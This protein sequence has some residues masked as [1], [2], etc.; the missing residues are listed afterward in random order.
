MLQRSLLFSCLGSK[1]TF[2]SIPPPPFPPSQPSTDMKCCVQAIK[3]NC[4]LSEK[5]PCFV[6]ELITKATDEYMICGGWGWGLLVSRKVPPPV[7][8]H[9][10]ISWQVLNGPLS[11]AHGYQYV[12]WAARHFRQ[13]RGYHYVVCTEWTSVTHPGLLLRSM[14]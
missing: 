13:T 4:F 10:H 2:D 3:I 6:E 11:H 12:A 14:C 5:I 8:G 1:P 9:G 7:G